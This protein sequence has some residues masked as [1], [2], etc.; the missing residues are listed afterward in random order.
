MGDCIMAFWNAPLPCENH[1]DM[2]V[3]SAIEI[4]EEINELKKEYRNRD[5]PDINVGTGVNTG[6]CIVGN[7]G[8]ESRF[9]YS[10]IGDAVNLAARLEST[11]GRADYLDHK[12]IISRATYEQ[13]GPDF[14]V[15]EIGTIQVKGKKEP[16]TIY[17]PRK[18]TS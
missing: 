15:F 7:M 12:T 16:I 2:A 10:V 4:E 1:A 5:L 11:A 8:S 13:L 17:S 9:D 3:K 6:T 18:I 14:A